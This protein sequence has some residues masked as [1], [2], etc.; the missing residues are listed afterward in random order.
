MHCCFKYVF[1]VK[2][3]AMSHN[4]WSKTRDLIA[5]VSKHANL[6]NVLEIMK[7]IWKQRSTVQSKIVK[8]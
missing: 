7:Q 3:C 6:F 5:F 2:F 4:G 8:A 1:F